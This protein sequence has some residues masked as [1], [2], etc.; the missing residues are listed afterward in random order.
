MFTLNF[1]R[2]ESRFFPRKQNNHA[3]N[4][5]PSTKSKLFWLIFL[6]SLFLKKCH[7]SKKCHFFGK[8]YK[9]SP[10]GTRN[11]ESIS[12]GLITNSNHDIPFR[13]SVSLACTATDMTVRRR[14]KAGLLPSTWYCSSYRSVTHWPRPLPKC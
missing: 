11:K 10:S 4:S 3:P 7:F 14:P 9:I 12:S 8:I 5:A 13:N 6:K 1:L 2:F